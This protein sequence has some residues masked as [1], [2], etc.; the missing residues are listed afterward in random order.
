M[1]KIVLILGV[2]LVS[3]GSFAACEKVDESGG[4]SAYGGEDLKA[5]G[6]TFETKAKA[7]LMAQG[8]KVNELVLT[9]AVVPCSGDSCK[10]KKYVTCD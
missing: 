10:G 5:I 7:A 9:G 8:V 1:K 2:L 4:K 6:Y 3:V